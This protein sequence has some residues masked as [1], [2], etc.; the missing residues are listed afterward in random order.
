[1]IDPFFKDFMNKF[2]VKRD[3]EHCVHYVT[4]TRSDGS[5]V[6]VCSSWDCKYEKKG[7]TD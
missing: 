6:K 3:C 1:M 5:T 2:K 7:G 4:H